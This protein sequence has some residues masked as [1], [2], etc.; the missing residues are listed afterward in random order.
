MAYVNEQRQDPPE[1][2]DPLENC[3]ECGT[4][5]EGEDQQWFCSKTCETK[6][7]ARMSAESDAYARSLLEEMEIAKQNGFFGRI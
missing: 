2:V 3:A 1:E 5:L 4:R 7:V 6:H